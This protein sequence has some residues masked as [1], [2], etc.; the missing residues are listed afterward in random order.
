MSV[1]KI[2]K[3]LIRGKMIIEEKYVNRFSD[4]GVARGGLDELEERG[5]VHR[6]PLGIVVAIDPEHVDDPVTEIREA[7]YQSPSDEVEVTVGG[8]MYEE[9]V[10]VTENGDP[11]EFLP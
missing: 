6:L 3:S 9:D 4:P 7:L 1:L 8:T 5:I 2:A 10:T 11:S